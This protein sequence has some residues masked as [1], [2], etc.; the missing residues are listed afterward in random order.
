MTKYFEDSGVLKYLEGLGFYTAGY[1]CMTCIGNSGDLDETV[2]EAITRNDLVASA[3]LSGNRNF[4]GRVHALTRANYLA[5]P[6][7]VVAYALAGTV[8]FDFENQPLGQDQSGDDV[9]LRDIWPNREEI[10]K[11]IS[12]VLQSKMFLDTYRS[13]KQGS[14]NWAKLT[15]SLEKT[16]DW[17]DDSTYIHNPPFFDSVGGNLHPVQDIENAYCLLNLG[18]SIT[19]D[20]ISPA[21]KIALKSPAAR[22]LKERDIGVLDFNTYGARRGNDEIMARGTFAN[23]RL[24]NKMMGGKVGPETI[25][26]P[27]GEVRSVFDAAN[28]YQMNN[29]QTVVLAGS[30]YGSGSSRDWA[31]KGPMLLGV[32]GVIAESFERIHRSNLLGM[33]VLPMCFVDGQNTESLGLTGNEQ[34]NIKLNG[35]NLKVNELLDVTTNCGKSFKVLCRLDTDVE[36]EYYRNGGILHYVLR[37]MI[38]NKGASA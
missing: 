32:R 33:G 31:A 4:E 7:L 21:G 25:H 28:E 34:F 5:S 16:Y 8:D 27:T 19:T 30:E 22:Y 13:V 2:A 29:Q 20:H 9:Y 37:Q 11:L 10:N 24:V 6:P 1:G 35:G 38:A 36:V 17:K 26:V 12:D 3:V 18:D 15:T 23:I 14:G